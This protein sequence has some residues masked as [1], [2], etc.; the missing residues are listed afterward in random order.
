MEAEGCDRRVFGRD[1]INTIPLP[2]LDKCRNSA[3]RRPALDRARSHMAY[4]ASAMWPWRY[5]Y[6]LVVRALFPTFG[7]VFMSEMP[8]GFVDCHATRGRNRH[9]RPEL[10]EVEVP[11]GIHIC[12]SKSNMTWRPEMPS[13][14][15][16]L[17]VVSKPA[18]CFG[19]QTRGGCG[20]SRASERVGT[21]TMRGAA[22][23]RGYRLGK[24]VSGAPGR[25]A[26]R[27]PLHFPVRGV[28]SRQ[29]RFAR[30]QR[31]DA[32]KFALPLDS[33]TT[34]G[35]DSTGGFRNHRAVP[36]QQASIQCLHAS[37][38]AKSC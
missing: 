27:G 25:Q 31:F 4:V 5:G 18:S 1:S 30:G 7:T 11:A 10:G 32:P 9:Y 12:M 37:P 23:A 26:K 22:S 16:C 3:D 28:V 2:R 20:P 29:G 38:E 19:M 6:R 21:T 13:G 17:P 33:E 15:G 14:I 8:F 35:S 24:R 36:K 34:E